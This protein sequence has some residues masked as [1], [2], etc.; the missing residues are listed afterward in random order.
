MG[1]RL[2]LEPFPSRSA[3]TRLGVDA[4]EVQGEQPGRYRPQA[5]GHRLAG[6]AE[7]GIPGGQPVAAGRAVIP[8]TREGDRPERR[9]DDLVPGR[10]RTL[11]GVPGRTAPAGRGSPD[12]RLAAAPA[13]RSPPAA[14]R[15]GSQPRQPPCPHWPGLV[16]AGNRAFPAATRGAGR[17]LQGC[18]PVM[19]SVVLT[20]RTA[21]SSSPPTAVVSTV[22]SRGD[23][24]RSRTRA[25]SVWSATGW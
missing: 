21:L 11:P 13:C 6:H 14:S 18:L 25:G 23:R 20:V 2:G 24:R 22:R 12:R 16:A 19:P 15:P 5:R 3:V 1:R 17:A 10:R 9:V 7:P 4:G 8:G